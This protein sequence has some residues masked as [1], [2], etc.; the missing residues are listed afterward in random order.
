MHGF[1]ELQAQYFQLSP[2][3]QSLFERQLMRR[4]RGNTVERHIQLVECRMDLLF[5]NGNHGPTL[6]LGTDNSA[7]V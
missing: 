4:Y 7:S 1:V 5:T 3:R 6:A 2:Q